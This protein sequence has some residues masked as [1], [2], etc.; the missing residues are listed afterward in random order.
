MNDEGHGSD[1]PGYMD[2]HGGGRIEQ[3][4]SSDKGNTWTKMRDLTPDRSKYPGW[5]FNN[6]QP[7]TR[8]DGSSVDFYG[9]KDR[10]T[11]AAQAFLL[12]GDPASPRDDLAA[13][14]A[15]HETF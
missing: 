13:T 10:D 5:K 14:T 11:P 1:I 9:W 15:S 7:V 3:W 4:T 12:H 2:K 8:P 6:I